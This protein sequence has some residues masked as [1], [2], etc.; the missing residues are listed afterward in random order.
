MLIGA[1]GMAQAAEYLV[2]VPKEVSAEWLG[3][4][5]A[6]AEVHEAK[7]ER[8]DGKAESLG[9]I[10]EAE[11]PRYLAVVGPASTFD[12]KFVRALNRVSREVD[13]DP[14]ADV[15]WGLITG[16]T[17][18]DA[19]RV[20]KTREPLVIDRAL[21]TTGI[22]LGLVESG[23]TL[24]DGGKGGYTIKEAGAK[25]VKG[26]WDAETEP[27]GTVG[28]FEKAWN[29][30][31][32]QLLVTSS[33]ATQFNL[34]M[35]FGLGLIASHGG[36]FHV[37][38]K[39]LK[40]EFARFL[41]G[42]MFTGDPAKL[43]EWLDSKKLPVLADSDE[44]KVWVA[45]GNCLIGDARGTDESMVVSAMSSG[46][47][48]Q[49]VGYVV[50]TWFGRAGWGTLRLWQ[51]SRGSLS[52]NEAFFLN[53]ARVIE[54]TRTRFPAA[55]EV[56]FDAD[57]I[58]S[59]MRTDR[60]FNQALGKLQAS[61]VKIEKDTVGL[62]H[63]RDVLAFW[64]DPAWDA[65]FDPDRLPHALEHEWRKTESGM[66]LH[67]TARADFEGQ[68]LRCLPKRMQSAPSIEL[69]EGMEGVAADDFVFLK[70]FSMKKGEE[71]V[72]KLSAKA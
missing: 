53:D 49:F 66:E 43:G 59:C 64:G 40:N 55:L 12:G 10:L 20:V 32:P 54:E 52:L 48:R 41:G 51:D 45:A 15:R 27:D 36:K 72:V 58:E 70:K 39:S 33:H 29:E 19:L 23:L 37:L 14:Y 65:R 28:M 56:D 42:A 4:G 22:N 69:P 7:L 30:D 47:F 8:F 57:D 50:P 62:I 68:Y 25:P 1:A 17:P 9:D 2:A 18:D 63:D 67:L 11:R 71:R 6:L 34:E 21:T 26:Q 24:S 61:G 13:D 46:G 38:G 3:V 31:R 16:A 35:P 44:P 5:K 60:A